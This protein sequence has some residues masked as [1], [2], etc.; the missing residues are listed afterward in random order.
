MTDNYCP[1]F[2]IKIVNNFLEEKYYKYILKI[3]NKNQFSQSTQGINGKN[4]I[5][6]K[7]KIRLDYTLNKE[8]CSFIDKPLIEKSEC[9][10]TLRERWRILFY[11][12]DNNEKAF[13]DAHTDWTTH[14]CHRRMSIIISLSNPNDYEGGELYFKNDNIKIKLKKFSAVIFD[15]KMV[16]EVLPVVKGKR[17]MLQAFLFDESGWNMK[18]NKSCKNEFLLLDSNI[19]QPMS[20]DKWMM[21]EDYNA[22]HNKHSELSK[23]FLGNFN[24]LE[25][26]RMKVA[27]IP[28]LYVFTWHGILLNNK[29]AGKAYGFTKEEM[30]QMGRGE[31]E[32]WKYEKHVVSCILKNSENVS[33]N[34]KKTLSILSCD[35]GPGNQVVGIKEGLMMAKYLDRE[36]IFPPI[37]Q[38]YILNER[39]RGSREKLKI[40]NFN[41]IF[42]YKTGVIK[43]QLDIY[44]KDNYTCY[45]TRNADMENPLRSEKIFNK[46]LSKLSLPIKQFS[47]KSSYIKLTTFREQDLL[48]SHLYNNTKISSCYWNGCDTCDLNN[49]FLND[50]QDICRN[51]DFSATIKYYA[52][53]Y[54]KQLFNNEKFI[55]I[56][57]RYP[58]VGICN[59]KTI[60]KLYDESTIDNYI[61][62]FCKKQNINY[63]NVF[64][65]TSNQSMV[66]NSPLKKYHMLKPEKKYNELESFIEQYIC[67]LSTHFFYTGG[68]H[69]KSSHVHLRSTWSSFVIDYRQYVHNNNHNYYFSTIFSK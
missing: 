30:Y 37:I 28:D 1:P 33:S 21:K 59:I 64:I 61:M 46:N 39:H 36:F 52:N 35:G 63:K 62:E 4:V 32:S 8:E 67:C 12:G 10:C 68:I 48:I 13:R 38:H 55:T 3:I 44:K 54:I 31:V 29:W 9:G 11:D 57:M 27:E 51:L 65:C 41:E 14:S 45:Y 20:V 60:N 25:S 24:S 2:S 66:H 42:D 43:N 17:Y 26:V 23:G 58:D 53:S 47:D 18:V 69:A 7:H 19:K 22:I 5:Q 16:H 34:Q 49:V 15:G 50:Y 56:H 6:E 40:W